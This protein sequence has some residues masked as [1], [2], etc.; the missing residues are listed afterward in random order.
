MIR[1]PRHW[2]EFIRC[3]GQIFISI[4][5]TKIRRLVFYTGSASTY[6]FCQAKVARA[7][8]G[9]CTALIPRKL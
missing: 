3:T 7:L 8:L 6:P 2:Y 1:L 4:Q 9:S 5:L